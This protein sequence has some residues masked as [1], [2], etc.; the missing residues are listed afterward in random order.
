MT[1]QTPDHGVTLSRGSDA[2]PISLGEGGV[3]TPLVT[4]GEQGSGVLL[5]TFR[6]EPGQIG[7]FTLP[8]PSGMR[9][10]IYYVVSGE[11]EVSRGAE[12]RLVAGPGDALFFRP[13]RDYEVRPRTDAPVEI[14]WTGSPPSR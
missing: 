10:E 8:H 4:R 7:R 9:E 2:T 12:D 14:V 13:G 3:I 11:L 6:L 1:P 5:G